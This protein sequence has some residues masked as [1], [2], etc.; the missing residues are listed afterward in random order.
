MSYRRPAAKSYA[1]TRHT[2]IHSQ[3]QTPKLS[4]NQL[5]IQQSKAIQANISSISLFLAKYLSGRNNIVISPQP[6]SS[7]YSVGKRKLTGGQEIFEINVPHWE[8]YK[9][10][11]DDKSKYRIYRNGIWHE[12]QH[13]DSTPAQVYGYGV[14]KDMQ[15]TEPLAHDVINIIEDRRIE[16]IGIEKWRGYS[17]ERL[18]SNG[19][20][21]TR[22]MDCGDFWKAYLE[23]HFDASTNK[24]STAGMFVTQRLGHMRH[25]AFLQRLL[26]MKI[27]GW[28]KLPIYE[29]D[30]IEKEARMVE[31]EL[32]KIRRPKMS[33]KEIFEKLASLTL[34]V[35]H[36]L[37]LKDYRP[38][39]TKVG[40]SSWDQ[41]FQS[42]PNVHRPEDEQQ[43]RQGI[44]DYFDE[45]LTVEVVCA[46]CGKHY[47]RKL[48]TRE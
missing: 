31:Q 42:D 45:L 13:I 34:K 40:E 19:Y 15:V 14:D 39:I 6:D 10:P 37:E 29:R 48:G 16:D 47:T 23:Q 38:E 25:E 20:A 12:G 32:A 18:F 1:P 30:L 21:W 2:Q 5:A 17:S 33:D 4:P 28:D 44:D 41:S 3:V 27:K 11:L 36:D 8:T 26:V 9:L 43:T 46:D 22:R 35:I 7:G 24:Y